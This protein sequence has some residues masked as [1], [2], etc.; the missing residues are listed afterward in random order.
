MLKLRKG[1]PPF[2]PVVLGGNAWI[3]V[4]AATSMDVDMASARVQPLIMGVIAG[5]EKA[6]AVAEVLGDDFSVDALHD[7]ALLGAAGTRLV[8]VF[9]VMACQDG[10]HGIVGPDGEV[11]EKPSEALVADLLADP[12]RRD[13]IM[14]VV[15]SAV[16]EEQAEKNASPASPNGG[17]ATPT[18]AP[19][20]AETGSPAPSADSSKESLASAAAARKSSLRRLHSR[21]GRLL[22]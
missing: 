16:H 11:I 5:S 7:N 9:L 10:W 17:A 19:P 13:R 12:M 20:A 3:R 15:E 6:S 21:E 2:V 8:Q 4:R 1:K 22:S 14:R 18:G